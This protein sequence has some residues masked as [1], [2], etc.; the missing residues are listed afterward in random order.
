VGLPLERSLS[1]IFVD[2]YEQNYGTRSST[3]AFFDRKGKGQ[4]YE[5]TYD[6]KKQPHVKRISFGNP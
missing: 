4:F 5:V 3:L 1:S 2:L 6:E